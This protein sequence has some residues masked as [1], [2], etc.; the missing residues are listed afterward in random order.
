MISKRTVMFGAIGG[1]TIGAVVPMLWGDYNSF[2][3]TSV[4]MSMVGGFLGIW[5]AVQLSKFL[6]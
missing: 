3:I 6:E 1:M 4:L 2:G 5:V